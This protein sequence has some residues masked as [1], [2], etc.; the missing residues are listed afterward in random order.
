[1]MHLN[2]QLPTMIRLCCI[3]LACL[4]AMQGALRAA[5]PVAPPVPVQKYRVCLRNL[6][7]QISMPDEARIKNYFIALDK[8]G[9]GPA[10]K[11]GGADG[12]RFVALSFQKRTIPDATLGE[13]DVSLLTCRE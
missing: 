10:Q 11:F 5:D 12:G 6:S 4:A 1:M 13:R 2:L 3:A 9:M 8:V 7:G